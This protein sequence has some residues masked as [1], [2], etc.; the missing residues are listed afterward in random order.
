MRRVAHS[1]LH[2]FPELKVIAECFT[3]V[4]SIG[5]SVNYLRGPFTL[6][7]L[8]SFLLILGTAYFAFFGAS[9]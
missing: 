1:R 6:N 9:K 5:F 7:C 4:A 3:L 2:W 8:L